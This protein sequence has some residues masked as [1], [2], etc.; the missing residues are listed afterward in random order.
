MQYLILPNFRRHVA[1]AR[2]SGASVP[3]QVYPVAC[4][5]SRFDLGRMVLKLNAVTDGVGSR[6]ILYVLVERGRLLPATIASGS[7]PAVI[8]TAAV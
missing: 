4:F 5:Q 6:V 8:I 7:R 3:N 1:L 2:R